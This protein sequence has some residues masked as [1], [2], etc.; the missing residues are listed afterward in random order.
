MILGIICI[1]IYKYMNR[2]VFARALLE[3]N[4][5]K[6]TPA[7]DLLQIEG[8][9]SSSYSATVS[10]VPNAEKAQELESLKPKYIWLKYLHTLFMV[11]SWVMILGAGQAF[12]SNARTHFPY[13]QDDGVTDSLVGRCYGRNLTYPTSPSW[14]T[15]LQC[16]LG[17]FCAESTN[18]G[19]NPYKKREL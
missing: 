7:L 3:E 16:G 1:R 14:L 4:E 9:P 2:H 19:A 17:S 8:E 15:A 5:S 13:T 10:P 6:P 18:G 11:Y 12:S